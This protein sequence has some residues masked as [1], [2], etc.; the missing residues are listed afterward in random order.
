MRRK[1]SVTVQIVGGLGNQLFGYFAGRYLAERTG[2]TLILDTSRI[3]SRNNS[4]G[5]RLD[6]LALPGIFEDSERASVRIRAALRQLFA[7]ISYRSPFLGLVVNRYYHNFTSKKLGY[8]EKLDELSAPVFLRGYFQSWRFFAAI[9]GSAHLEIEPKVPS[10]WYL[11]MLH[12]IREVAPFALHVRRGDYTNAGNEWGLL[13]FEYYREA[14]SK[15]QKLNPKKQVWVFSD[16]V[17]AAR[18]L[19][20]NLDSCDLRFITPPANSDPAESLLLMSKSAGLVIANSTFSWWAARLAGSSIPIVAPTRWFNR[21]AEPE[22]L[23]PPNWLRANS[24]WVEK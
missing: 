1:K 7:A 6:S 12:E 19:L 20:R 17:S 14:I 22:D 24:T 9:Q 21:L 23:I 13:G 10:G 16:D 15:L 4:H 3:R 2:A 5:V 18:E 8:D 11:A